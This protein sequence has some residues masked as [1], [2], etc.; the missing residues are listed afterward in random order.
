MSDK[1]GGGGPKFVPNL[2]IGNVGSTPSSSP[3]KPKKPK[4]DD[5]DNFQKVQTEHKLPDPAAS[6]AVKSDPDAANQFR[7]Q[8]IAANTGNTGTVRTPTEDVE[9]PDEGI[10]GKDV[11]KTARLTGNTIDK[12][13]QLGK[14]DKLKRGTGRFSKGAGGASKALNEDADAT[15]RIKGG[16]DVVAATAD[17]LGSVT[18]NSN[19]DKLTKN[20]NKVGKNLGN[21]VGIG[22]LND[23][24]SKVMDENRSTSSRVEA[25]LDGASTAASL[26]KTGAETIEKIA[27]NQKVVEKIGTEVVSKTAKKLGKVVAKGMLKSTVGIG[28]AIDIYDTTVT[29]N[30]AKRVSAD[31]NATF[32]EKLWAKTHAATTAAG[33]LPGIGDAISMAGDIANVWLGKEYTDEQAAALDKKADK[34]VTNNMFGDAMM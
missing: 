15:T 19:L 16:A 33:L 20:A 26:G 9:Q 1:I 3:A 29:S 27:S 5:E 28:T 18:K 22:Y 4:D 17:T 6:Q 2:N 10:D 25:G 31:P 30:H 13:A 21:V 8:M 11:S 14:S 24:I 32:K 12:V 34:N 7:Q 23:N